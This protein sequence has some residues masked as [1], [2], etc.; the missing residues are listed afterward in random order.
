M[1]LNKKVLRLPKARSSLE[2]MNESST[3]Q[4]I[5]SYFADNL[6]KKNLVFLCT[7]KFCYD[8]MQTIQKS[9]NLKDRTTL[10]T[11]EELLPFPE[12]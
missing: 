4:P 8:I 11:I 12:A 1:L 7:G 5:Y 2:E 9:E 3:F 10:L 6:L